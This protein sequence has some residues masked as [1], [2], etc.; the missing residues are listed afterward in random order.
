MIT[1]EKWP[2]S[3]DLLNDLYAN[4]DQT[5]CLVRLPVP[6]PEGQTENYLKIIREE[7]NEDRPFHCFAILLDGQIIGK[8]E[9]TCDTEGYAE[10]DIILKQASCGKG[11][12][13]QAL[14]MLC[15]K[16]KENRWCRQIHAYTDS[17]NLPALKMLTKTG[18]RRYRAFKA[19]VMSGNEGTY[20]IE[21]RKGYEYIKVLEEQW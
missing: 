17:E 12:G 9:L 10:L 21:T 11:Y 7:R 3:Y 16:A 15:E 13:T 1:L 20:R 6:L 18:F 19:D 14:M 5:H 8:T 2:D 4:A